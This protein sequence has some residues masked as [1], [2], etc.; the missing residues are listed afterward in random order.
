[1]NH[2]YKLSDCCLRPSVFKAHDSQAELVAGKHWFTISCD[3]NIC[4][5]HF[6]KYFQQKCGLHVWAVFML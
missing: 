6:K 4:W 1:M 5:P 3:Q 2:Y